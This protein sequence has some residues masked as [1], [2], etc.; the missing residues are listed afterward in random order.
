[1]RLVTL[2]VEN[3]G[4]YR[5]SQ[6]LDLDTS[7]NAPVV[8]IE[9][10]NERGK[11]S[12]FHA[13]RW[14]LYGRVR[15]HSGRDLKAED[16]ANWD[17][18]DS[19][20]PF[21]FGSTLVFEHS[22]DRLQI[23]RRYRGVAEARL[24]GPT[25]T[26]LDTRNLLRVV[27][28]DPYPEKDID[29]RIQRIL[30]SDI[31]DFFLFDGETLRR[32]EDMLRSETTA[33]V[34]VRENLEKALGIPALRLLSTDVDRLQ[35][36]AG[37][38][39]RKAARA[40]KVSRELEQ[41]LERAEE[42][43]RRAE[44]DLAS[45]EQLRAAAQAALD[46]ANTALKEVDKIKEAYYKRDELRTKLNGYRDDVSDTENSIRQ[47]LDSSWWLPL[48]TR[49]SK[50]AEDAAE[51]LAEHSEQRDKLIGLQRDLARLEKQLNNP[52]CQTCGQ[53]MPSDS[54][55]RLKHERDET[56]AEIAELDAAPPGEDLAIRARR[57]RRFMAADDRLAQLQEFERDLKRLQ[58]RIIDDQGRI[59][60][61]TEVI[62]DEDLDIAALDAQALDAQS[63]LVR[64][65]TATTEATERR[66][67]ALNDRKIATQKI[68]GLAGVGGKSA[69]AELEVLK[70]LGGYL[71]DAIDTF[72]NDMR[73][74]IQ[75]EASKIFRQL[76]TEPEYAGLRIDGNYYLS[77]VNESD[78]VITRRSAGAD[79]VVTLS[80]IGA[81][82]KCAVEEGPIVM[83]TPFARL[84]RGHRGRILQWTAALG[85][86]VVLFVQSGEFERER[87][88]RLLD[89][90][91][92][93][94]YVLRRLTAN[95]TRIDGTSNG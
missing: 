73:M 87:D 43:V 57:L 7:A 32:F 34:F 22:G 25:V 45:L 28:G 77:I 48:A 83:D 39:V 12:L 44:Q 42:D 60:R 24:G 13:L 54:L 16:F 75:R 93:R 27:G 51:A 1:M 91:V 31:S 21:W 23:A 30:H 20:E 17:A 40:A 82:A 80:L 71:D 78:R 33:S 35:E 26:I 3:W 5:G 88:L 19:G 37:D 79:Q 14:A 2:S 76:T 61:L 36:D 10:E 67:R 69:Q 52:R 63:D 62:Q 29:A 90:R 18:R 46:E 64:I 50:D 65:A 9:G 94:S 11:T 8:L 47:I 81:L 15:D 53:P 6:T 4:P 66:T 41:D 74:R 86:Q 55:N 59:D 68:A 49:L 89:G 56:A 70:I 58:L 72:R 95:S 92:G 85:S 38:A 84:D